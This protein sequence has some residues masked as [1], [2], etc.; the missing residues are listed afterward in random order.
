MVAGSGSYS[1]LD[2]EWEVAVSSRGT[3]AVIDGHTLLIT[4]LR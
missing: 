3:A 1:V 2:V 4:P